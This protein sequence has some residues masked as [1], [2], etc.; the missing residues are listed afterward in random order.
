M[1]HDLQAVPTRSP[2]PWRFIPSPASA[3]AS[4][5]SSERRLRCRP[6]ALRA[7]GSVRPAGDGAARVDRPSATDRPPRSRRRCACGSSPVA[8]AVAAGTRTQQRARRRDGGDDIVTAER[9]AAGCPLA[10]HDPRARSGGA[11]SMSISS[12]SF[13]VRWQRRCCSMVFPNISPGRYPFALGGG[14]T[15]LLVVEVPGDVLVLLHRG[16]PVEVLVE[17]DE[18]QGPSRG[19]PRGRAAR[20]GADRGLSARAL[21]RYPRE[22]LER[23]SAWT[24]AIR[25]HR[26][27]PIRRRRTSPERPGPASAP[28]RSRLAAGSAGSSTDS[29]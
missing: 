5:V 15:A 12:D 10:L 11:I 22:D 1:H 8:R 20:R 29:A 25:M 27:A 17:P 7:R 21:C 6:S 16:R 9:H 24:R 13:S 4:V 2:S 18:V 28:A 3:C 19:P 14:W 26:P 23:G